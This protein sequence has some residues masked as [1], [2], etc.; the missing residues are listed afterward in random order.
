MSLVT[1]VFLFHVDDLWVEQSLVGS[2]SSIEFGGYTCTLA[3]PEHPVDLGDSS[4]AVWGGWVEDMEGQRIKTAFTW[5]PVY[6]EI[7]SD[8]TAAQF[9]GTERSADLEEKALD[10]Y[11]RG[12]L[13]AHELATQYVRWVRVLSGQSQLGPSS[14]SLSGGGYRSVMFDV[15][16]EPIP[17]K[18]HAMGRGVRVHDR[19]P[20][21]TQID[22]LAALQ[23]AAEPKEPPLAEALLLDAEHV[24]NDAVHPDLRQGVL[25]AAISCEVKVKEVLNRVAHP[26]QRGALDVMLN[27]PRDVSIP[28]NLLFHLGMHA[29]CERSLSI[30]NPRLFTRVQG[31]FTARNKV[32]HLGRKKL[33]PGE[34]LSVHLKTAQEAFEW[35]NSVLAQHGRAGAVENAEV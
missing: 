6:V 19:Q 24:M 5:L 23:S 17:V 33:Q 32:A 21:L 12:E 29:I 13:V 2:R 8:I 4:F 11:K 22:H 27:H 28:V 25:L 15:N 9:R 26:L 30:E 16:G 18:M 35:L 20:A 1:I 3:L 34:D 31:L 10:L 7:P 14:V